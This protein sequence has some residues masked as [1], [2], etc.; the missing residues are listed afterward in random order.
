MSY[1]P[2]KSHASW[3]KLVTGQLNP[4]LENFFYRTKIEQIKNQILNLEISVEEAI[5]EIHQIS[6]VLEKTDDMSLNDLKAIFGELNQSV[7]KETDNT[8][9]V[10][11]KIPEK[12]VITTKSNDSI[13]SRIEE[14]KTKSENDR[15]ELETKFSHNTSEQK[16]PNPDIKKTEN[17]EIV[18]K[19]VSE[20]KK[21]ESE[22]KRK[23][24][25]ERRNREKKE[26]EK[27]K[28]S[29]SIFRFLFD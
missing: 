17:P 11:Q 16:K 7:E 20:T 29:G 12:K 22:I 28:K 10:S 1:I 13:I 6:V 23:A 25:I 24:S 18:N 2:N 27:K 14:I 21:T 8:I 26:M 5:T 19:P 9:T 4:R 3:E 15:K